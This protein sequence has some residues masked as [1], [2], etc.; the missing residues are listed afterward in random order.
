MED[1]VYEVICLLKKW[2]LWDGEIF[3]G[4]C[5]YYS[6]APEAEEKKEATS[7][8]RGLEDVWISHYNVEDFCGEFRYEL[9]GYKMIILCNDSLRDLFKHQ[10]YV[11]KFDELSDAAQVTVLR[12][13]DLFESIT[14]WYETY[15]EENAGFD[16][17]EFDS[18]EEYW[19]LEME[20]QEQHKL[21]MMKQH[22]QGYGWDESYNEAIAALI[23]QEFETILK[24]RGLRFSTDFYGYALYCR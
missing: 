2:N 19:E 12:H 17:T 13:M 4:G 22:L 21:K 6:S 9:Q 5:C 3:S 11:A 8:W 24:K 23:I 16:D 10:R 20:N 7:G 18:F 15:R 14:E 1:L